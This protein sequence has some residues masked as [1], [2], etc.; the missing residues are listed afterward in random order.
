[1]FGEPRGSLVSQIMI[2]RGKGFAL[3]NYVQG[4]PCFC[5]D[6][7]DAA[8]RLE[9]GLGP[10]EACQ[11]LDCLSGIEPQTLSRAAALDEVCFAANGRRRRMAAERRRLGPADP[12][13]LDRPEE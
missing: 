2:G 5:E 3:R 1:M 7:L 8:E 6:D 10:A 12:P 4:S 9:L 13:W 11:Q